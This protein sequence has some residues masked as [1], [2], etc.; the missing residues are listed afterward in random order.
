M[1]ILTIL[2]ILLVISSTAA[3]QPWEITRIDTVGSPGVVGG[4]IKVMKF[5]DEHNECYVTVPNQAIL[6]PSIS[7]VAIPGQVSNGF[8]VGYMR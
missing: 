5:R 1:K 4:Y 7:C 2:F 8:T 6:S 3:N